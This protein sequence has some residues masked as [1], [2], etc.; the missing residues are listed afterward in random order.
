MSVTRSRIGWLAYR[1]AH[2]Q[3]QPEGGCHEI[4]CS[5]GT[6]HNFHP[7]DG[8]TEEPSGSQWQPDSSP[9]ENG[10]PPSPHAIL[11]GDAG[12]G[13]GARDLTGSTSLHLLSS[14]SRSA[15]RSKAPEKRR[16]RMTRLIA[17]SGTSLTAARRE[18]DGEDFQRLLK[19]FHP[20]PA[21][22]AHAY[23]NLR[24]G[25]MR[26]IRNNNNQ[27]SCEA[28]AEE[29]ADRALDVTAKKLASYEIKNVNEY[30]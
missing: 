22:A 13:A 18:L 19:R 8:P 26:S 30:A 11:E 7:A 28:K 15:H 6:L 5:A 27:C 10:R 16:I 29:L 14:S 4:E 9:A 12:A 20:D 1:P 2:P 21:L 23:E 17:S 25:L 3:Q 24:Q